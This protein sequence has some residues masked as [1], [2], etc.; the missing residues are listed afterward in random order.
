[1]EGLRDSGRIVR[2]EWPAV[3]QGLAGA[4][5]EKRKGFS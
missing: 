3:N 4:A 5:R 2:P 1:M